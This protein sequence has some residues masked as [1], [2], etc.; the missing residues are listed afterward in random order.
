MAMKTLKFMKCEPK[1]NPMFMFIENVSF[2]HQSSY[3]AYSDDF[4]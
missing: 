4:S 1:I 2:V 3:T